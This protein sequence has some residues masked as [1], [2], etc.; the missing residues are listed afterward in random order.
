MLLLDKR[1]GHIVPVRFIGFS[2]VGGFGILIHLM[3]LGVLFSQAR[4]G[5]VSAQ[6]IATLVA[7]T[8]NFTLNNLLTYYDRRL[9][10]WQ[11]LQGWASFTLACSVGALANVGIASHLFSMNTKWALAALAG[12]LVGTVWNYAV[13]SM[14]TWRKQIIK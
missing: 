9:K 12:I 13:T 6:S 5:F 7:M 8:S 1:I 4:L 2:L 3:V 14:Y 10:G 11:W